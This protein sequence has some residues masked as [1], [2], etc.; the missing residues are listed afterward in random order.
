MGNVAEFEHTAQEFAHVHVGSTHQHGAAGQAH[1]LDFLNHGLVLLALRLVHAVV[2]VDAGNGTVGG[3]FHHVELIDVPELARLGACRTG[4]TCELVVHTEVVLQGNGGEGLRGGFHLHVFLGLNGLVQAVAPAA[5]LHDTAGLF[6]HNLHCAVH[7]HVLFVDAE[8][9]VGFE[10]L[11]DGMHA[12]ALDGVV[13]QEC[14]L[15]V[16]ALL[17][18]ERL[19]GFEFG[20]DAGDVGQHEELVVVHLVGEP[21][22]TLVCEVYAV[23]LLVHH[24]VEGLYCLGHAAV[25]VLHV[26]FLGLEHTGLDACLAEELDERIVLRQG[27]V[28]AEEL[29]EAFFLFLL[30]ARGNELFGFGKVLGGEFA[31]HLHEAFHEGLIL[32]KELVV[33]LRHGTGD[34]KRRTGIVNQHGVDLIDDG[35]VV[36]ALHEVLGAHGHVV[37]QVVEA[38]LVVRTKG[39]VG[40]IS[41]AACFGV[42]LVLVDAVYGEAVEHIER[43]HPLG[44]ALGE[45]VVHRHH[46]H[47]VAGQGVEED[48]E[49]THK[50]FT[51]TRGHFGDFALV[52][53]HA[54]EELH[55]VVHH[56]PLHVVAA[57][58]PVVVVDGFVALDSH[59]VARGGQFAVKVVCRHFDSLVLGKAA[60]RILHDGEHLGECFGER[61]LHLVEHL[62]FEFVYLVEDNLAVFDGRFLDFLLQLVNLLFDVVG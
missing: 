53:H 48:G 52:Q 45:V 59:K 56:V 27:L 13:L 15:A 10:Q 20:K 46:V 60:R 47:A 3:N 2:H 31:L 18:G 44:V 9:G 33:A 36:T 23:E 6:V 40:L 8:H 29:Q 38:E 16:H 1:L 24:E 34:D 17:V 12:V 4:H 14:V 7:H 21:L 49:R 43:A 62:R 42:G 11:Q 30:V 58:S 19:V 32:L 25:V 5:A 57:G 35:V 37:A 61:V 50:G 41:A 51:L 55:I 39:D 26:Y 28:A 22:V 54:A